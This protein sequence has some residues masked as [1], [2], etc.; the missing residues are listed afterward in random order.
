[1]VRYGAFSYLAEDIIKTDRDFKQVKKDP[2][3]FPF[4]V[5]LDR[6]SM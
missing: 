4:N 5:Y 3:N 2:S 6:Y 1:M